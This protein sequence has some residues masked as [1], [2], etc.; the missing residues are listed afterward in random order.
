MHLGLARVGCQLEDGWEFGKGAMVCW[1]SDDV[2]WEEAGL[3]E[4]SKEREGLSYVD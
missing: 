4:K 2:C 1:S 3:C